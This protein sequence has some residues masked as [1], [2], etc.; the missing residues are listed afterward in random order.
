MAYILSSRHIH[1]P[2]YSAVRHLT[3]RKDMLLVETM[4]TSFPFSLTRL[5]RFC[6]FSDSSY[7]LLHTLSMKRLRRAYS[8]FLFRT[9]SCPSP[10]HNKQISSSPSLHILLAFLVHVLR[11]CT[12]TCNLHY[13]HGRVLAIKTYLS[14]SFSV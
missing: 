4:Q 8:H 6:V 13:S 2:Q 5:P 3:T 10:V 1:F 7:Y 14:T 11:A 12:S 9:I